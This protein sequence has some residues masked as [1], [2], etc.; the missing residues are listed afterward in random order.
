MATTFATPPDG[1]FPVASAILQ[2][3]SATVLQAELNQAREKAAG[4]PKTEWGWRART[5]WELST[6]EQSQ[7]NEPAELA[8][9]LWTKV[10]KLENDQR[11]A[12]RREFF[13]KWCD[14]SVIALA[15]E[16]RPGAAWYVVEL[17]LLQGWSFESLS[18][19]FWEK[20][21]L[22]LPEKIGP[23]CD[24]LFYGRE[25]F[26]AAIN[27]QHVPL[28]RKPVTTGLQRSLNSLMSADEHLNW[29]SK[30]DAQRAIRN[31]FDGQGDKKNLRRMVD[32]QLKSQ[33]NEI[34]TTN[35]ARQLIGGRNPKLKAQQT[36]R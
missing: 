25:E 3:A 36:K 15:A 14:G 24:L 1:G 30:T 28:E 10:R 19:E 29:L 35:K 26:E 31:K 7:V 20:S 34:I 4:H 2:H 17:R 12:Q 23:E 9:P 8:H 16:R 5:S 22:K 32:D 18:N 6:G 11:Q 21:R 27:V 13:G 33:I